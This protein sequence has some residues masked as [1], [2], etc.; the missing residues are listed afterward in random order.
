MIFSQC[1]DRYIS[2]AN[3]LSCEKLHDPVGRDVHRTAE[4]SR[5][6]NDAFNFPKETTINNDEFGEL[7]W[8]GADLCTDDLDYSDDFHDSSSNQ[9]L[10]SDKSCSSKSIDSV[11]RNEGYTLDEDVDKSEFECTRIHGIDNIEETIKSKEKDRDIIANRVCDLI[12][13]EGIDSVNVQE[14]LRKR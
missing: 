12:L 2:L 14:L 11:T 13:E 5:K 4:N 10:Y 7:L 6:I 1:R 3:R 8:D 9:V